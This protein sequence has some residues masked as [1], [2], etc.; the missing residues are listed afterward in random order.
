MNKLIVILV[1]SALAVYVSTEPA[2][3]AGGGF[4]RSMG[5]GMGYKF[6]QNA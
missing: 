1:L 3:A 4:C 5:K 2:L 6:C